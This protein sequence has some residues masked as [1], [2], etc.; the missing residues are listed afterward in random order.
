MRISSH[1]MSRYM[2]RMGVVFSA[3]LEPQIRQ[4]V[5]QGTIVTPKKALELG[6]KLTKLIRRDVYVAMTDVNTGET[7]LGIL[8]KDNTLKTILTTTIIEENSQKAELLRQR[9]GEVEEFVS[10]M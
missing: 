7:L 5:E 3:D 1:A 2:A 8:A 6:F 9:M 4:M 10:S